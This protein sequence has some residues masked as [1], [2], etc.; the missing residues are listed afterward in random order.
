M[1]SESTNNFI[2]TQVADRLHCKLTNIKP[3]TIQVANGVA[4]TCISICKNSQCLMQG[5]EFVA[6]VF[7]LKLKDYDMVLGI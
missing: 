7:I 3:L 5:V 2:S 6:N 1:D 4:M